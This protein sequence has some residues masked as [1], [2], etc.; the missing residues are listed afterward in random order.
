MSATKVCKKCGVDKA[1]TE[2]YSKKI[3]YDGKTPRC[4][5][6][7]KANQT[8][9][10]KENKETVQ[11]SQLRFRQENKEKVRK[12]GQEYYIKNKERIRDYHLEYVTANRQELYQKNREWKKKNRGAC[13]AAE[14]RRRAQKIQATPAWADQAAIKS[15]YEEAKRLQDLLG[16]EFHIDHVLPL[17]GELVCGLHVETNLQ[18]VPATLNMKKS[19]KFKVE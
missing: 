19:N 6:C 15:L 16:I 17:Q 2:Y 7:I 3:A 4:K 14:A 5:E 13:N 10:R 8:K 12:W 1:L 9:Y 18:V 11:A